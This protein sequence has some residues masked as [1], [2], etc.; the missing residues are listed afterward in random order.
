ML[1]GERAVFVASFSPH[2]GASNG[3]EV[4]LSSEVGFGSEGAD[5][6]SEAARGLADAT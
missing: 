6:C 1:D 3:P 4:G 5:P 2:A